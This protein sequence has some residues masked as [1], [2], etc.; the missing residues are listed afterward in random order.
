ME[1]RLG[2]PGAPRATALAPRLPRQSFSANQG[3]ERQA[4]VQRRWSDW[5]NACRFFELRIAYLGGEPLGLHPIIRGAGGTRNILIPA[6]F[7]A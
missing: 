3:L 2:D 1:P 5:Q 4:D 7:H 6:R